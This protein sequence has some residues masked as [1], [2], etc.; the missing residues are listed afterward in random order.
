[1][2]VHGILFQKVRSAPLSG[3]VSKASAGAMEHMAF[4][5]VSNLVASLERLKKNGLWIVGTDARSATPVDRADLNVGMALVVGGEGKG[6]RPLVRRTCDLLVAVPQN[7]QVE[8]LNASVAA[9]IV[10]YEVTRQ[11]RARVISE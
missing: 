3:A 6:M 5:R 8:S 1:M 7:S 2:G 4:A 10:L 11:R 9:A